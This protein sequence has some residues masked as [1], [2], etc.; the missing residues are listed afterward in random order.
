LSKVKPHSSTAVAAARR[1]LRECD[2]RHP[3][4][5]RVEAIA[6]RHGAMVV[7][8]P[9]ATATGSIVRTREHAVIRVDEKVR[10]TPRG[11]FTIG[12]ELGHHLLHDVVDH[13]AQCEGE[14]AAPAKS[15]EARRAAREE[16]GRRFFVEREA[17]QFTAELSMPEQWAAPLCAGPRPTLDDVHRLSRTFRTS[18]KASALR[19][20]ELSGAPCAFVQ[21]KEGRV[22]RSA[23]TATFP[24]T[25][26][27]RRALHPK[28]IAARLQARPA[29]AADGEPCEVPGEA[30]G[31]DGGRG[32]LE[33]AIA[34]GPAIGVVSWI[35]AAR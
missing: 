23:E 30:W 14:D 11:D 24:G 31:D 22:K 2:V 28:S 25:I 29:S 6:A 19:F 35:V 4:D 34:L 12:H 7:Y 10:A 18:F 27:M 13:F 1:V 21:T 5:I 8:G 26:V 33:H 17:N 32:F 3:R 20:V 16:T 15:R 9:L